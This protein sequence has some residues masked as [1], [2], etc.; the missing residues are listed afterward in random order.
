MNLQESH[1]KQ[2]NRAPLPRRLPA[3]GEK[4]CS[5]HSNEIANIQQAKEIDQVR[6]NFLCMNIDLNAS[7]RVAQ[8][9]KMALAHIA[10]RRDAACRTNGV[11]F[12]E[13]LT[14][15]SN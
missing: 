7:G 4:T 2:L 11:P 8:V 15:L 6:A 5:F 14:H 9:Q 13:L 10:M 3:F 12:L 1:R